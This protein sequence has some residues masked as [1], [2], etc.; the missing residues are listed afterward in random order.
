MK[1][2]LKKESSKNRKSNKIVIVL[3]SV[4]VLVCAAFAGL[5]ASGILGV[6]TDTKPA[7]EEI[8]AKASNVADRATLRELLLM[9]CE[10]DITV[11]EDMEI[12]ETLVVNGVK[13]VTSDKL[14]KASF[15]MEDGEVMLDVSKKASLTIDGWNLDGNGVAQGVHVNRN[16]TFEHAA[17]KMEYMGTYGVVTEGNASLSKET[18]ISHVGEGAFKV[19]IEGEMN[20][21]GGKYTNGGNYL[22]NV[23]GGGVLNISGEPLFD[24]AVNHLVY[25]Y[26]ETTING[27]TFLNSGYRGVTNYAKMTMDYKG[28]KE[29][30][31]I[32][33]GNT[34]NV[35]VYT[36]STFKVSYNGV[37]GHDAGA[38]VFLQSHNGSRCYVENCTFDTG[39]GNAVSIRGEVY[40]TGVDIRNAGS[41]GVI[42]Q[43]NGVAT[44]KDVQ[45]DN[46]NGRGISVE[47]ATLLGEDIRISGTG[48]VG[49]AAQVY[50]DIGPAKVNVSNVHMSNVQGNSIKVINGGVMEFKD[51]VF[52]ISKRTSVMADNGTIKLDGV[53][54]LG[55]IDKDVNVVQVQPDGDLTI[56]GKTLITGGVMRAV[57]VYGGKFT[58]NDG[59]IRNNSIIET[60]AAVH[61][62]KN[63]KSVGVF[64]MNG[65]SICNN[66]T[67]NEIKNAGGVNV[68]NDAM[69][70]MKG[71][72]IYGNKTSGIGGGVRVAEGATFKMSGG[73]IYKNTS[74]QGG[75]VQV[76]KDATFTMTG[77][78]IYQNET[79]A[80]GAG[81]HVLGNFAIS[82]GKIYQ[83]KAT[84]YG[85]AMN[86]ASTTDNKTKKVTA[87]GVLT[88]TGGEIYGNSAVSGGGAIQVS[89]NTTANISG[90]KITNNETGG[91]GDGIRVSGKVTISGDCYVGNDKVALTSKDVKL[92]VTGKKLTQHSA[93]DPLLV[94]VADGV[95]TGHVVVECD[96]NDAAVSLITH[97]ASGNGSYLLAQKDKNLV[98]N[99][100]AAD[101][102]MTGADTV[103]VS[104]F[105]ELKE[106]IT[107]TTSKR[108]I[109]LGAD[110]EMESTI[111][112]PNGTTVYIRDDGE[113][114]ILSRKDGKTSTFFNTRYG[115]GIYLVGT[116]AGNLVL[117]GEISADAKAENVK[118]LVTAQGGTIIDGV[119]FKNNGTEIKELLGAFI[120]QKY[121]HIDIYDSAFTGAKAGSGAVGIATMATGYAEN[122]VFA[123]NTVVNGGGAIRLEKNSEFKVKDSVFENNSAGT[124]G[125]AVVSESGTFTAIDCDFRNN[126]AGNDGGVIKS[127]GGTAKFLDEDGKQ[128]AMTANTSGKAGGAVWAKG[129]L[130]VEEYAFE[131]NQSGL[132]DTANGGAIYVEGRSTNATVTNATFK[133]NES[134]SNCGG[135]IN[136]AGATLTITNSIFDGNKTTANKKNGGAIYSNNNSASTTI[137]SSEFKNNQAKDGGAIRVTAGTIEITESVFVSNSATENGGAICTTPSDENSVVEV[138]VTDTELSGNYAYN[139][140]VIYNGLS[141]GMASVVNT[142][143][144]IFDGNYTTG[145]TGGAIYI[146]ATYTDN[147]STFQNNK[148][149]DAEG[150][151]MKNGG[152]LYI[153][154]KSAIATLNDSMFKNNQAKTGGAIRITIG[155][156]IGNQCDF[157][158]NW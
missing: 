147:G 38:N 102:D 58:M 100:A 151:I 57:A 157:I 126:T 101:M 52:E 95:S 144:C 142:N 134:L 19:A 45:I 131:S 50:D 36:S 115:T 106:A 73:E 17:G 69:F 86:I 138:T 60:G 41:S 114:R 65:G 136:N 31:Y 48:G 33:V 15:Q 74:K 99:Y 137:I 27:G 143:E 7:S 44:F 85:G 118:S 53:K 105:A 37:Y 148:A 22:A 113:Q 34:E 30:G 11:T 70:V 5:Y 103:Y 121:G 66:T 141:N 98:V 89:G 108:Y 152:A 145:N 51:S 62:T 129:V 49:I 116:K 9:D 12:K 35:A 109:V 120:Y 46:S 110:I 18:E 47:S 6:P 28:D 32:E 132:K 56:S 153:Q 91:I 29:D 2:N 128:N 76:D 71:G 124:S 55:N 59:E 119:T 10:L 158:N 96:D 8:V 67:T 155:T 25:N 93:K 107:S 75:G 81:V 79:K 140:G 42:L 94:A 87:A 104:N 123:D 64:T 14:L 78:S 21:K 135:A 43:Q 97:T 117:D 111:T 149:C 88:M 130:E 40:F 68:S 61:I 39:K 24:N 83:N 112:V 133:D 84:S 82:G 72:K 125:G 1:E 139:G 3:L 13:K 54:V 156:M 16:A 92:K 23:E 154:D 90:G 80:S 150:N 146:Q 127:N 77:G 26:G 63:G 20:V 122:C 4:V